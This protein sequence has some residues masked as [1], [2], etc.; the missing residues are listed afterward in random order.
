MLKK[1]GTVAAIAASLM[2]IGSPAFAAESTERG[3]SAA[4]LM[5]AVHEID[6]N[7][8]VGLVNLD[9]SDVLSDI[10]LCHID[11]NVIAVPVL[12]NGDTGICANV[13]EVEDEHHHHDGGYGDQDD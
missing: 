2:I 12:S 1:V 11:V 13:D 8:Q 4:E 7:H 3:E 10:N 9:D 6:S 5:H